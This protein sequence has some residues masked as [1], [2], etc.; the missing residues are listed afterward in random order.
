MAIWCPSCPSQRP[1]I[2]F[3]S[4]WHGKKKTTLAII[5]HLITCIVS[6]LVFPPI[7]PL[8]L[9][10]LA[11]RRHDKWP[12]PQVVPLK[13]LPGQWRTRPAISSQHHHNDTTTTSLSNNATYPINAIQVY[14][15]KDMDMRHSNLPYLFHTPTNW[16][17]AKA[18]LKM[19]ES[20]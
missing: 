13:I 4:N 8:I 3:A 1:I 2:S 5:S 11:S 18:C 19:E 10:I 14:L 15:S 16:N 12:F 9:V 20:K 7:M 17:G 6:W